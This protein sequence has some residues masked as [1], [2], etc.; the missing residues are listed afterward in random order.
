[1]KKGVFLQKRLL[2]F[3]LILGSCQTT[4]RKKDPIYVRPVIM[5]KDDE[6]FVCYTP[7][8]H[9]KLMLNFAE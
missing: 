8:D 5:Y 4:A 2:L 3:G 6:N 7:E 9:E 1:M